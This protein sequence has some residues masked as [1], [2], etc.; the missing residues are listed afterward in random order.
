[1]S[2]EKHIISFKYVFNI[3]KTG[4]EILHIVRL[5][6]RNIQ[7]QLDESKTLPAWAKLDYKR[8]D[9]CKLPDTE[10]CPVAA[11]L[12]EP[13]EKFQKYKSQFDCN[14][15]VISHERAYIKET[16]IQ[17]GL[18]SLFGLLMATSGCPTMKQ[19]SPMALNHLPFA[20]LEETIYRVVSMHLLKSYLQDR[21]HNFMPGAMKKLDQIYSEVSDVNIAMT[22]RLAGFVSNDSTLNAVVGLDALRF[23][24]PTNMEKTLKIFENTFVDQENI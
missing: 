20:S 2:D 6:K 4:E 10:Y 5:D 1:M 13:I 3:V 15:T 14:V 9:N 19:L 11:R 16:N 23:M 24:V 18:H 7:S 17:D 8:C 21:E 22:K 12:V